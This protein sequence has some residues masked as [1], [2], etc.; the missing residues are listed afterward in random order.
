MTTSG[1]RVDH[2]PYDRLPGIARDHLLLVQ[3]DRLA[4]AVAGFAC[5]LEGIAFRVLLRTRAYD[6]E[7]DEAVRGL[8]RHDNV[9]LTITYPTGDVAR[10]GDHNLFATSGPLL[11]F[12]G[13]GGGDTAWDFDFWACPLPPPGELLFSVHWPQLGVDGSASMQASN[14]LGAAD[15]TVPLWP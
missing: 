10:T 15:E 2:E 7:V 4:I 1:G 11:F 6:E 3:D 14:L 9:E 5:Y 13:G 12:R 8:F